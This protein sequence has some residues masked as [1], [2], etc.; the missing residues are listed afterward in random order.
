MTD[1]LSDVFRLNVIAALRWRGWSRSDL[2][3]RLG[4]STDMVSKTLNNPRNVGVTMATLG[5]Y[6]DA[7]DIDAGTLVTPG[8]VQQQA[9]I[10]LERAS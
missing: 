1:Y 6:S 3:A 4:T 2:A 7:L 10:R 8:G 9:S 5:R